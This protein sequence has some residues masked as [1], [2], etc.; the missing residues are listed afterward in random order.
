MKKILLIN[1][2]I[3]NQIGGVETYS[4]LLIDNFKD[5]YQITEIYINKIDDKK[6]IT[7][8]RDIKSIHIGIPRRKRKTLINA[9]GKY[10]DSN[11]FDFIINQTTICNNKTIRRSNL[12]N[13]QHFNWKY[14][15]RKFEL[16]RRSLSMRLGAFFLKNFNTRHQLDYSKNTVFFDEETDITKK[17]ENP[18]Y[19]NLPIDSSFFKKIDINKKRYNA[20]FL[21]RMDK[22]AVVHKGLEELDKLCKLNNSIDLFGFTDSDVLSKYRNIEKNYKGLLAR[23][24]I[25]KML[26]TKKVLVM[27]STTEGFPFVIVEAMFAGLPVVLFDTFDSVKIFEKSGAV[28]PFE[29]G[30]VE[31]MNDKIN[32]ITNMDKD[33]YKKLSDKAID[34]AKSRFTEKV[35]VKKWSN[36]FSSIKKEV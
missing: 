18:F 19:I 17:C 4:R 35:F 28:F 25:S 3:H 12:I 9:I 24:E 23:S 31:S 16:T 14:Y 27:T 32:E 8:Q 22:G 34:F 7:H 13:V 29:F 6:V 10:I 30:D 1:L 33:E 11:E 5:K 26:S 20:V 2:N 15:S 36:L 21:G